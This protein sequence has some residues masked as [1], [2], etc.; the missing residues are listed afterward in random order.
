MDYRKHKKDHI[1]IIAVLIFFAA[2]SLLSFGELWKSTLEP[3]GLHLWLK[4]AAP[5]TWWGFYELFQKYTDEEDRYIVM[6]S[7]VLSM[8]F[9]IGVL[10]SVPYSL[11]AFNSFQK[12]AS[13]NGYLKVYLGGFLVFFMCIIGVAKLLFPPN[14][15][16]V[17]GM[18]IYISGYPSFIFIGFF[19]S[20]FVQAALGLLFSMCRLIFL[21]KVK[22][23]YEQ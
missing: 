14:V 17:F 1:I 2:F 18:K 11:K 21:I 22:N 12:Y 8:G 6:F 20:V 15:L 16:G 13:I 10:I 19:I 7:W 4:Q 3:I 9:F 23:S 5:D